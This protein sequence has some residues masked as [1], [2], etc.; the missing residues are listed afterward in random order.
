[1]A[2]CD[3]RIRGYDKPCRPATGQI[4]CQF[5]TRLQSETCAVAKANINPHFN[6]YLDI[7]DAQTSQNS[8]NQCSAIFSHTSCSFYKVSGLE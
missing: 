6:V 5:A 1:M 7:S 8:R 3:Q 4:E 2:G